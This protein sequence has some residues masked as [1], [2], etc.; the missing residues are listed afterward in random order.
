M[1][2]LSTVWINEDDNNNVD[3]MKKHDT[4]EEWDIFSWGLLS[5][6]LYQESL[7][8]V[9]SP[10]LL[11]SR[12]NWWWWW[13][14]RRNRRRTTRG[15]EETGRW[16][17]SGFKL[18]VSFPLH[19]SCIQTAADSD[20]LPFIHTN[21]SKAVPPVLWWITQGWCHNSARLA[22]FPLP[23][24]PSQQVS[25]N[26]WSCTGEGIAGNMTWNMIGSLIRGNEGRSGMQ[27]EKSSVPAPALL[28]STVSHHLEGARESHTFRSLLTTITNAPFLNKLFNTNVPKLKREQLPRL[29]KIYTICPRCVL[30]RLSFVRA[31]N[32]RCLVRPALRTCTSRKM[33]SY[34]HT[35]TV[36][37]FITLLFIPWK[38]FHRGVCN[39]SP[40]PSP[41]TSA[42][43]FRQRESMCLLIRD[44]HSWIYVNENNH[45]FVPDFYL[46]PNL[47]DDEFLHSW[48]NQW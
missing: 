20:T 11:S 30:S 16:M 13:R 27:W 33:Q 4:N 42:K 37:T 45:V 5:L 25:N 15:A 47:L 22:H 26:L 9:S 28:F 12:N 24:H 3:T 18:L 29:S 38:W 1:Y 39:P 10:H 48:S 2:S 41:P 8:V 40:S 17:E 23:S 34:I 14:K 44:P 31:S 32:F 6:P 36:L 46:H 7:L 43:F 21:P 19:R 35:Q